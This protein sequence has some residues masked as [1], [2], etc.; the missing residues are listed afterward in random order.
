ME[1][2]PRLE[3]DCEPALCSGCAHVCT[4]Q[5]ADQTGSSG[6]ETSR[7]T[8]HTAQSPK[9]TNCYGN[10]GLAY[11]RTTYLLMF[12]LRHATNRSNKACLTENKIKPV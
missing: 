9:E 2:P 8:R 10:Q 7:H 3:E 5:Q 12:V 6:G 4:E 1:Q 11:L